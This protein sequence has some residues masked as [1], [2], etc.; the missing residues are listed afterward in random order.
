MFG[1]NPHR[2]RWSHYKQCLT[3]CFPPS[4]R[5]KYRETRRAGCCRIQRIAISWI[6][7]MKKTKSQGKQV[8]SSQGSCFWRTC[9]VVVEGW[10]VK[11]EV[12]SRT[13]G[14]DGWGLC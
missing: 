3:T 14:F 6:A 8:T 9:K 1:R 12:R 11:N 2:P 10:G 7:W 5:R 13:Y 4:V